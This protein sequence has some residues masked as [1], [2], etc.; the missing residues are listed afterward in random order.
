MIWSKKYQPN[1]KMD[2]ISEKETEAGRFQIVWPII[3]TVGQF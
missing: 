3:L 1:T 2:G